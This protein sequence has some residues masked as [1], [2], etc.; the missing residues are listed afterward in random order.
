MPNSSK[1]KTSTLF[2][3]AFNILFTLANLGVFKR[4]SQVNTAGK[5][6]FYFCRPKSTSRVMVASVLSSE[7]TISEQNVAAGIF[8]RDDKI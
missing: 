1:D 3:L 2:F 6:T 5:D 4:R 8:M 7:K